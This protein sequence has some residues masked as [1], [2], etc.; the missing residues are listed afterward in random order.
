[1]GAGRAGAI[2]AA[3]TQAP[4]AQVEGAASQLDDR[5]SSRARAP[6]ARR[7]EA[8][9]RALRRRPGVA[10]PLRVGRGARRPGHRCRLHRVVRPRRARAGRR[11]VGFRR[12]AAAHARCGD[13]AARRAATIAAAN[14]QRAPGRIELAPLER[15]VDVTWTTPHRVDPFSISAE[16]KAA[17]LLEWNAAALRVH[18]REL[19]VERNRLGA[20]VAAGAHQRR[21]D[22]APDLRADR[23]P[24]H[25]HRGERPTR[26]TF[27]AAAARPAP[28]APAGS[29]SLDLD[30]GDAR[31]RGAKRRSRRSPRR[32][33]SPASGTWCSI[34]RIS[35]SPS[36]SRSAIRPS[37]TA[38]SA[39]RRTT[40]GTSF[41][42]PPEKVLGKLRFGPEIMQIEAN[43]TE[44][45]GCATC[46]WDD[47]RCPPKPG[48]WCATASS[49]TI[50]PRASRRRAIASLTGV[51]RSH[52]CS[53]AQDWGKIP[54]QRM[55]N[56][57]LQPG[58]EDLSEDDVLAAVDRG[59][60]IVGNG[61]Y[62]IDQQR[63]N[64]QFGGQ[65]FWEIRG[66][67]KTRMLRDVAYVSRTPDFWNSL[68]LLGGR[69]HLRARRQLLRRQG[70]A[71]P[72]QRRVAR[73]S[74]RAL[75]RR[76]RC[77]MSV[78][79]PCRPRMDRSARRLDA[80]SRSAQKLCARVLALSRAE[81]AR[82]A[83]D[84]S[85]RG[86]TRYAVNRITS[87][88]AS[89]DTTVSIT[90]VF[91]KR[92]ATVSTNRLDDQRRSKTRCAA[93]RR[94]PSSRPRT[95]STWASS[96]RRSTSRCRSPPALPAWRTTATRAPQAAAMALD[97]ARDAEVV[98]AGF[99]DTV[100]TARALAN[101]KGLFAF[102]AGPGAAHTLT[103]RSADG[104]ASG[105]AGGEAT[106]LSRL[107]SA[108]IT[109]AA[110]DKCLG[111][112]A[113]RDLEPGRYTA[114][115]EP[116]AAGMLLCAPARAP[117]SARRRRGPLVLL[118]ARRRQSHRRD[119]VRRA[120]SPS[121]A[122]PRSRAPRPRRSIATTGCRADRCAGSTAACCASWSRRAT[123]R[124]SAASTA[125][126]AARA[127]WCCRSTASARSTS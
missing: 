94:W 90:S 85:A 38:R 43:R 5:A 54:F 61:S 102:H 87:A 29:T 118:Q 49:S 99:V 127:T 35:G 17:L 116:T 81:A 11:L 123:G 104:V 44:Q 113:P 26:A 51:A 126:G 76:H 80:R 24:A 50:R 68:A 33:S 63:Y 120:A 97:G 72:A 18:G 55:P 20:R 31:A 6:R 7:G 92:L 53:Y 15:Q 84:D 78:V 91:G 34:P 8:R 111:G 52:G 83:V 9:R 89:D 122:I 109:R 64:F 46:G 65:A 93:P 45:G 25:R 103:M 71:G 3:A 86:F 59:I 57:S 121:R 62:S 56:V 30:A 110:I 58:R 40:P 67:K 14:D 125:V 107:D 88:G 12:R 16:E 41:L 119:A 70:P 21:L 42:A 10:P 74:D 108:R 106:L 79:R 36:T 73:L 1:M 28:R 101:T 37:S 115:L 39:T 13:S 77:S 82:V 124:A 2:A 117:R 32:P 19:R 27:R 4:R 100:E 48:R 66:G 112:R 98:A 47:E 114:I 22:R 23:S 105:W 75:S 95:P 96:G 69:A 60:L